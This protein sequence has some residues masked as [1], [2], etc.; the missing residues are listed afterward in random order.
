LC[1]LAEGDLPSDAGSVSG[2]LTGGCDDRAA[3]GTVIAETTIPADTTIIDAA[4][5]DLPPTCRAPPTTET[6]TAAPTT[7]GGATQPRLAPPL[8]TTGVPTGFWP[9]TGAL[10]V[11]GGTLLLF[12]TTRR[13]SR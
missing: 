4:D 13:R 5:V 11:A 7:T 10:L 12:L 1:L 6:P 2:A 8:A 3:A 9:G